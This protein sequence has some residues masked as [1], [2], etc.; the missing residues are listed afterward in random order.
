[1]LVSESRWRTNGVRHPIPPPRFQSNGSRDQ[2]GRTNILENLPLAQA[3]FQFGVA[4]AFGVADDAV[5][6]TRLMA[7]RSLRAQEE[8]EETE[9]MAVTTESA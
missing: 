2:V 7:G 9:E 5:I 6:V 8:E 4:H 1:M 3:G